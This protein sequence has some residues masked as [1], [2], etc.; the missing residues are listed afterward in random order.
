MNEILLK[1]YLDKLLVTGFTLLSKK[2]KFRLNIK[3]IGFTKI[4]FFVEISVWINKIRLEGILSIGCS[5]IESIKDIIELQ[6]LI[7]DVDMVLSCNEELESRCKKLAEDFEKLNK[8]EFSGNIA[9]IY[10]D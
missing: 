3:R 9:E 4:G 10:E 1:Y 6:E 8:I 2:R 7:P 5:N